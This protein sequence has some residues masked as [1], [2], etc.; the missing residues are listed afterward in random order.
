MGSVSQYCSA[1]KLFAKSD[2]ATMRSK[3]SKRQ[4]MQLLFYLIS[5]TYAL[6]SL[7]QGSSQEDTDQQYF[8]DINI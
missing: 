5:V 1:C 2:R 8:K 6:R 7:P 4:L 3:T